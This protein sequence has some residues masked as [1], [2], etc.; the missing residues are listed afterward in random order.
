MRLSLSG[1]RFSRQ[2]GGWRDAECCY[3]WNCDDACPQN[4]VW[5]EKVKVKD[6]KG[7]EVVVQQPRVGLEL[8]IGCGVCE[9]KCPVHGKPVVYVLSVGESRS[10]ENRLLLEG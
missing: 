6:R 1:K 4:A 5:L 10:K 2:E 3:C 9:T 7:G 8:C